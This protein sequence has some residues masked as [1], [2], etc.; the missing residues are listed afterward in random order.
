MKDLLRAYAELVVRVGVNLQKDQILIINAPIECA[1]FARTIAQ[2]AF[3]AGR[4][5]LE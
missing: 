3:A 1:A 2:Q 4:R 5:E